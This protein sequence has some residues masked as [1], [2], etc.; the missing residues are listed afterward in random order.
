MEGAV[1]ILLLSLWTA[2][3]LGQVEKARQLLAEGADVDEKGGPKESTP[4]H[5]AADDGCQEMVRLLLERGADVSVKNNDGETPLHAVCNTLDWVVPGKYW[6]SYHEI[7]EDPYSNSSL[8]RADAHLEA[9]EIVQ[10]L[11][12]HHADPSAKDNDGKTPLH[13]AMGAGDK[14]AVALLIEKGVDV[15]A[16]NSTGHTPL[17]WAVGQ[18]DCD[19]W[20]GHLDVALLVLEKGVDISTKDNVG[21][22]SMHFA[23]E[24][25]HYVMARLLLEQGADVSLEN[26]DGKTP[27]DVSTNRRCG[28]AWKNEEI[29]ALLRAEET[30]LAKCVMFAMGQHERLGAGSLIQTI[31]PELVKMILDRV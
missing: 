31:P 23:A 25:G 22:T 29:A 27:L 10:L 9:L 18:Q 4:L 12:Q 13:S 6:R 3:S 30:R 15:S 8:T 7:G 20:V 24:C 19:A 14:H 1:P 5:E 17:H 21:N 2:A 26:N 16:K 28:P 11:L